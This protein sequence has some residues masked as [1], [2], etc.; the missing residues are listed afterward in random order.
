MSK[1]TGTTSFSILTKQSPAFP[2]PGLCHV[3]DF[4]YCP[5]A[6][7]AKKYYICTKI[8]LNLTN[9]FMKKLLLIVVLCLLAARMMAQDGK[10]WDNP[11]VSSVNRELAH[12]LEVPAG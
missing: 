7:Y 1:V 5:L 8:R 10:E 3:P 6:L 9:S 12:A 2:K 11:K 4:L